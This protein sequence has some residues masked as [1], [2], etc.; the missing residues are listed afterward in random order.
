[1]ADIGDERVLFLGGEAWPF[2]APTADRAPGLGAAGDGAILA[3]MPGR[4][5]TVEVARGDAV[6]K[7]RKLI[8]LEAMKMEHALLAP[9]AGVVADLS[10]A[11][12]D[13]VAEGVVLARITGEG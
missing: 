2:D 4:V 12:G 7:G 3:P 5:T 10:V 6:A 8:V 11:V 1:M 9:F 13:Q